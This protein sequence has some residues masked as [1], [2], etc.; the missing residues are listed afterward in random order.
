MAV[1]SFDRF[2]SR[3]TFKPHLP[4]DF[5]LVITCHSQPDL[6]DVQ[7]F[8][9]KIDIIFVFLCMHELDRF[10]SLSF[11][12]FRVS[13]PVADFPRIQISRYY[14]PCFP[15]LCSNKITTKLKFS[16]FSRP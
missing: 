12:H 9:I 5:R 15:R 14:M 2:K 8:I 13:L 7:L 1:A 16:T 11:K 3:A 10:L 4:W 6:E